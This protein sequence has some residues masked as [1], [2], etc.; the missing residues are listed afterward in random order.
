MAVYKQTGPDGLIY[1]IVDL[2][3]SDP[4]TGKKR[5]IRR[6]AK[7]GKGRPAKSQTA[8]E[9]HEHR[10]REQLAKGTFEQSDEDAADVPTL[11][12][13]R[14]RYFRDHVAKLKAS[15]RSAQETIWRVSLLPTLGELPLDK[16]DAAA[17][18][19]RVSNG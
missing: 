15:S 9:Q 2:T 1:Y 7:D 6:A 8:A 16:I 5:R 10:I 19:L 3:W 4:Q 11:A 13:F 18:A 12:S 14:A 17:L